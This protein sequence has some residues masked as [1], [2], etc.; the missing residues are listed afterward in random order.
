M[1]DEYQPTKEY[2]IMHLYYDNNPPNL[3]DLIIPKGR[4][5]NCQF[6]LVFEQDG[7][8]YSNPIGLS[9]T[10]FQII[11]PFRSDTHLGV[12]EVV[13]LGDSYQGTPRMPRGFE[14]PLSSMAIRS[15]KPHCTCQH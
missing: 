10:N 14:P 3:G 7:E 1:I 4:R 11:H 9:Y 5:P 15:N 2:N 13:G 8:E 12:I 6:N